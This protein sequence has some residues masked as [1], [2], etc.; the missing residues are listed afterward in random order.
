[1]FGPPSPNLLHTPTQI[2]NYTQT[3][4]NSQQLAVLNAQIGN[5]SKGLDLH[6]LVTHFTETLTSQVLCNAIVL[7]PPIIISEVYS[8][9]ARLLSPT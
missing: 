9:I 8:S 7:V 3:K 4:R 1:M 5:F 6:F 2:N